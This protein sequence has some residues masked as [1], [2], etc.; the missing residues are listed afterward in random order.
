VTNPGGIL[1]NRGNSLSAETK[2]PRFFYSYIIV[3]AAF[4]I[5]ATTFGIVTT[6]GVFF[7]PL[8]TEF[9]WTRAITAGASSLHLLM[10]GFLGI[11]MGRLT[12]K[13]GPRILV[14]TLGS[15]L[16]LGCLLMS[17]VSSIWQPYLF[18]G[19]IAS[20]GTS[21]ALV[22]ITTT[23]ARWFAKRRGLMMGI[24]TAGGAG[25]GGMIM[26][27]VAGWCILAYDWRFS[28]IIVGIIALVFIILSG[29][30]L[31]RDPNQVG[32]SPYGVSEVQEPELKKQ[33][34]SLQGEGFLLQEAIR[35]RQFW[36]LEGIFFSYGFCRGT[37]LVHIVAHATDLGFSLTTG[38]YILAIITAVSAVSGIG[39]GR[40]ADS[41]GNKPALTISFIITAII[42]FWATVAKELWML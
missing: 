41:I 1:T 13:F 22:P 33:S 2:R 27:P 20:I 26:S 10:A 36:M 16:G 30:F 31:K 23:I 19:V 4:V 9:G 15:F 34:S 32:Q 38:A 8:L 25:I 37:I 28:Y 3:L 11:F 21:T 29:Q 12:D 40:L 18:W 7:K 14:M 39:M 5:Y 17:Q 6:F 24:V 35:T 42:L